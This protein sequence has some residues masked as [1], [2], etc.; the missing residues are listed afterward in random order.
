MNAL[1]LL[2]LLLLT[3]LAKTHAAPND[4]IKPDEIKEKISLTLGTKG[5]I[6]FKQEG[7]VLS[8]PVLAKEADPKQPGVSVEFGKQPEFLALNLKNLFPKALRY[9]AAIRLKGSKD[10]VETSL[11]LP[12]Y[13]GLFSYETWQDPRIEE[14]LLFDFKLTDE[15]L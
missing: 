5:I 15:K 2:A 7:N 11:V 12:V 9:R 13:A 6:Q 10:F 14:L 1:K 4:P 3:C 8:A